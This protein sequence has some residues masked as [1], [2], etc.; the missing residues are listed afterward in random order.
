MNIGMEN[1]KVKKPS[2]DDLVDAYRRR[3]VRLEEYYCG[4]GSPREGMAAERCPY[5]GEQLYRMAVAA[6]ARAEA[7]RKASEARR[8]YRRRVL[9]RYALAACVALLL[10]CGTYVAAPQS[11]VPEMRA[12]ARIDRMCVENTICYM[13]NRPTNSYYEKA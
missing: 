5:E 9:S 13:L 8:V 4:D 1:K 7:E 2:F 6:V 11:D 10:G 3:S 12:S